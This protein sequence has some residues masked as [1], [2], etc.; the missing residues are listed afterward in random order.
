LIEKVGG[1]MEFSLYFVS[2][3]KARRSSE[4][5]GKY[6]FELQKLGWSRANDSY[7][8]VV[9][10]PIEPE[11]A[12]PLLRAVCKRFGGVYKDYFSETGQIIKPK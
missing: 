9:R 2:E 1:T 10:K 11:E 6:G 12:E 5:L 4:F 8:V 7:Y 3:N